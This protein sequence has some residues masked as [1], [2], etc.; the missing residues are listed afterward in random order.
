MQAV[1]VCSIHAFKACANFLLSKVPSRPLAVSLITRLRVVEEDRTDAPRT[2]SRLDLCHRQDIYQVSDLTSPH[3]ARERSGCTSLSI[4][5]NSVPTLRHLPSRLKPPQ[6]HLRI[7]V[8]TLPFTHS[9]GG[10]CRVSGCR[11]H[12]AGYAETLISPHQDRT[13]TDCYRASSALRADRQV[14]VRLHRRMGLPPA[15]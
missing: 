4:S 8:C 14:V 11:G 10:L 2:K 5:G 9:L 3:V 13:S 7:Y 6:A 15:L 12:E 1:T